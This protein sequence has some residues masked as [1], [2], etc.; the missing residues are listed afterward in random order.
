MSA[1]A[2]KSPNV[3]LPSI[4]DNLPI[5]LLVNNSCDAGVKSTQ[6]PAVGQVIQVP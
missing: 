4:L 3:V 2:V 5:P 1:T 6:P